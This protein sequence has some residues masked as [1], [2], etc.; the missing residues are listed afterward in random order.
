[1]NTVEIL[2]LPKTFIYAKQNVRVESVL[3]DDT[4]LVRLDIHSLWV[5]C[6]P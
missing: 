5:G 3:P 4:L 1:M 6:G 2:F